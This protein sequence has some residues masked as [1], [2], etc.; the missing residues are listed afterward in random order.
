MGNK[1]YD[2]G[3]KALLESLRSNSTLVELEMT[4][5]YMSDQGLMAAIDR[6]LERNRKE[7]KLMRSW[8]NIDPTSSRAFCPAV[9]SK[10]GE[11]CDLRAM[12]RLVQKRP[13]LFQ[14]N[15]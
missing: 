15:A 5:N 14:G 10:A 3:A 12:Y 6:L 2:D 4:G 13:D 7:P 8:G 1:I 9:L 11:L